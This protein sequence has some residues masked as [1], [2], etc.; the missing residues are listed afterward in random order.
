MTGRGL[1]SAAVLLTA[2][3]AAPSSAQPAGRF[4]HDSVLV[5]ETWY[6]YSVHLPA[7]YTPGGS[8]PVILV[9]HG[10]G[11]R[12]RDRRHLG[13]SAVEAARA[14]PER[15]PAILVLPQC[16]AG[17]HWLRTAGRAAEAALDA[18]VSRYPAD[19]D[20]VYLAGQSMGADGVFALAGRAPGRYAALLAVALGGS[21]AFDATAL[22]ALPVRIYHGT[23]D[24]IPVA[25]ARERAARLAAAG[26]RRAAVVELAGRGHDIFDEVYADPDVA[27]WLFRQRR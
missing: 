8:W 23:R 6:P 4:V 11:S 7:G 26:N 19:A 20:R 17:D 25:R 1:A 24:R 15:Y 9:L 21:P 18:T 12:G 13:Q 14:N 22:R 5:G 27:A 10:A 2:T 3:A 16:P